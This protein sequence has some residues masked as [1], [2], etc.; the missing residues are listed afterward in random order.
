M[1]SVLI[2]CYNYSCYKLVKALHEQSIDLNIQFEILVSEDGGNT[3]IEANKKINALQ[4]CTYIQNKLNLGRAGNINRL[5]DRAQYHAKLI[6]DC[7]LKPKDKTFVKHYLE[8]ITKDKPVVCFGGILYEESNANDNLRYNY[9]IKREATLAEERL[10]TPYKSLL[11]SNLLIVHC[12]LHFDENIST[13]GYED[14]VFAE[15]LKTHSIP[16]KHIDNQL[17]HLNVEDN[18]TYFKK[19]E[20]ALRTLIKLE[21]EGFIPPGL[22]RISTIRSRLKELHLAF[23]LSL[24]H[25]LFGSLFK[26]II[27][28]NGRPLWMFDLYKLLYFNK[29]Y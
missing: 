25:F 12:H 11:T 16:V 24:F 1:L 5:L 23:V 22:T 20:T 15:N 14:L 21:N 8:I 9:G 4:N 19:T 29:H 18:S 3:H 6:L 10:K 7:D 27:L 13:Y 28:K 2:P 26:S 17:L